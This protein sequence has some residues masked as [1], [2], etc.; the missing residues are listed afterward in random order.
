MGADYF[1]N[2]LICYV[3]IV[4]DV[5]F[6]ADENF[7]LNLSSPNRVAF[8]DRQAIGT[9]LNDDPNTPLLTITDVTVTEPEE[10]IAN[11]VFRVQQSFAT[12]TATAVDEAPH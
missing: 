11:A 7:T 12:D 1:K 6:E 10:G 5:A 3:P 4:G 2:P 9:I 8:G